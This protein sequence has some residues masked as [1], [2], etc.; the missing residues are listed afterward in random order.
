[1]GKI[2]NVIF[3]CLPAELKKQLL[4]GRISQGGEGNAFIYDGGIL[5]QLRI[6]SYSQYGQDAFI[7]NLI[8]DRQKEGVFLEIG[9]NH[10][11]DLN[12]TYLFELN[13]WTGMAFEP[14]TSLAEKWKDTRKAKCYNVAV[15]DQEGQVRFTENTNIYLSCVGGNLDDK[16]GTSYM[17]PQIRLTDFLNKHGMKEI[18][19]A[20][21]DVETYEM[22]V[23]AG[24]DF[25]Q[26]NIT[27]ICIESSYGSS[28]RPRMDIRNFLISKGYRLVARLT[29]DDVFIKKSYFDV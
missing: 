6:E 13:G 21:I 3:E 26:T 11:I 8:F 14:I 1:M 16:N 7:F 19:V 17:V 24:I 2:R 25:D 28:I 5:E 12:N 27:C 22:N 18:D 23:L 29:I 20:F 15:G 10:P 9:A 4:K